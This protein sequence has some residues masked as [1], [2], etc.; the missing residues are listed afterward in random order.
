MLRYLDRSWPCC[1]IISTP[2]MDTT[3]ILAI[4]LLVLSGLVILF[5]PHVRLAAWDALVGIWD[6]T[7]GAI[8]PLFFWINFWNNRDP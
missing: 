4:V 6:I 8:C 1:V 5:V 3:Q 7:R 2:S